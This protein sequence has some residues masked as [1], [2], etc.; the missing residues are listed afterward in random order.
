MVFSLR[1]TKGGLIAAALS[2]MNEGFSLTLAAR[3][4]QDGSRSRSP[5]RDED[6]E[7][8]AARVV[9]EA[10]AREAEELE[11]AVAISVREAQE[12]E[13]LEVAAAIAARESVEETEMAASIAASLAEEEARADEEARYEAMLARAIQLSA[14]LYEL[15]ERERQLRESE[16]DSDMNAGIAA[17]LQFLQVSLPADQR[18]RNAT[19]P[20]AGRGFEPMLALEDIPQDELPGIVADL[21]QRVVE[22]RAIVNALENGESTRAPIALGNGNAAQRALGNGN[23]AQLALGNGNAAPRALEP[24]GN[25]N[26]APRALGPMGNGNAA[27]RALGPLGNGNAA[28]LTLRN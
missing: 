19:P 2:L 25:G 16:F 10:S 28:Q 8:H 6:P 18:P 26:A 20:P 22:R 9:L 5:R 15:E 11:V 14:E 23:A 17:S 24:M 7:L 21:E 27:P 13:D 3:P 1:F 4:R 12:A